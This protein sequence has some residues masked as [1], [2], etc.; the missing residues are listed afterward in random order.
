MSGSAPS[1]SVVIC[2]YTDDRFD[3]VLAAVDSVRRQSVHTR[4]RS[5]WSSTTIRRPARAARCGLPRPV[6]TIP[7]DEPQGLSGARNTGIAATR[8]DVVAFLDDDA[9]RGPT[10]SS[11]WLRPIAT[12]TSSGLGAQSCRLA[13]GRV[14]PGSPK[15]S[16]GSW[17][18]RIVGL[19]PKR[20]PIRNLIGA[21]MSF[22]RSAF[23]V[24][25]GFASEM[26]RTGSQPLGN[27]EDTEFCL[28][29]KN[30]LPGRTML[31]EPAAEVLHTVPGSRATWRYF[32][33]RCFAEGMTKAE[34]A[35]L[36]GRAD[37][38]ASERSYVARVLPRGVLRGISQVVSHR[39]PAGRPGRSHC[40]RAHRHDFRLPSAAAGVRLD[41]AAGRRLLQSP[42]D[43]KPGAAVR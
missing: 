3:D 14:R 15:S 26:G 42:D 28:R 31:Y 13:L 10:G 34:L 17:V 21:N 33:T 24:V 11:D 1:I 18:V 23:D 25:G 20:A 35:D 29:P 36:A 22:R 37:G 43:R 5:W 32:L 4:P 9:M 39:D 27:C 40:R 8:G 12:R 41:Y 38:L 19:P 30:A 16:I 6:V 2:C 7:N